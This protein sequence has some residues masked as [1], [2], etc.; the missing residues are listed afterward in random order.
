M[1]QAILPKFA[2]SLY[3]TDGNVDGGGET[4]AQM[5]MAVMVMTMK[6]ESLGF[7]FVLYWWGGT[8]SK[9]VGFDGSST[10]IIYTTIY[11]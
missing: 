4:M 7:C 9:S 3:F 8:P 1:L 2:L 6:D 10:L 11:L 5:A